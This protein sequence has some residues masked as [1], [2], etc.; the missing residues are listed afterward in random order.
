MSEAPVAPRPWTLSPWVK[1][2]WLLLL[3]V[4][5]AQSLDYHWRRL[6]TTAAGYFA[7]GRADYMLADYESAIENFTRSI[8]LDSGDAESY[9]WRGEAYAK[10]ADF[11]RAMPDLA[12]ALQLRPEYPKSHAAF[13]DGLAAAWDTDGAIREYSRAIELDPDY[14]R[15]FLERGKM[16]HD[17]G[18]WAEAAT[19][20]RRAASLLVGDNQITA[21]I[22]S[23]VVRAR[24]GDTAGATGELTRVLKLGGMRKN[25]FWNAAHF[26]SGDIAEPAYLAAAVS[27]K[28]GDEDKDR[29]E[30][31]FLA[32][33][34]HL[35]SGDRSG[36]V[37][38]LRKALETDPEGSYAYERS[39]VELANLIAGMQTKRIED[40]RRK[41]LAL[42]PESGL[43]ITAV[44]HGGA[45]EAAG[46]T[47]GSIVEA[48]E[49][50]A[51]SQDAFVS[52]LEHAA[53]GSTATLRVID[54][55]G[56]R[57]DVPL[58]IRPGSSSPTK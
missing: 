32:A 39:R 42:A 31:Y 7:R 22:F 40:D 36:A 10:L 6:P 46:I 8:G 29:A 52:L 27:D 43:A 24:A 37:P 20:L 58:A 26:L 11:T 4:I 23:W 45:A 41:Q 57:R 12:K 1:W 34:K 28:S 38:L 48:I 30:A 33:T 49:G 17:A 9:I 5:V 56:A 54:A 13:A 3:G 53:A 51:A 50:V 21:E 14:G 35:M 16:L 47:A 25:R 19:D 15:C 2:S 44:T 18:R 55:A